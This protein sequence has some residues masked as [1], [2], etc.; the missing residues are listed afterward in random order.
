VTLFERQRKKPNE[1][2]KEEQE[3]LKT[4]FISKYL[5]IIP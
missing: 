2:R 4:F 1:R 3:R 5:Q